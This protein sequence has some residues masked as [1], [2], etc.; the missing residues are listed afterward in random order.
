VAA[1]SEL[2]SEE[3]LSLFK[4]AAWEVDQREFDSLSMN[5]K[6]SELG[7]DSVALLEIFGFVEEELDI[8]LPQEDL[9]EV[10]TL[11]DLSALIA[12]A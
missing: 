5:T 2:Q 8:Y 3:L 6:I 1:M 9:A 7:V 10:K 11:G 12:R 4:E